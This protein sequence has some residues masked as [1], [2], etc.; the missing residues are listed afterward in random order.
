M[1]DKADGTEWVMPNKTGFLPWVYGKFGALPKDD[2]SSGQSCGKKPTAAV[3]K[4]PTSSIAP[5]Q[6]FIADM[7]HSKT[8]Y[9][10]VLLYHGLGTGKTAA[11]LAAAESHLM[12]NRK[13]FVLLPASLEPNY[14]KEILKVTYI[15]R[16][17]KRPWYKF[18]KPTDATLEAIAKS[19]DITKSWLSKHMKAHDGVLFIPEKFLNEAVEL[20]PHPNKVAYK[21]M[22][23]DDKSN[24]S[25]VLDEIINRK[26]TFIKYNGIS[27]AKANAMTKSTFNNAVVVIDEAHNF[28]LR[29]ANKSPIAERL[30][31]LLMFA[32]NTKII[33]LSGT[34]M[35]NHP[36]ELC[37]TLNLLRG[38]MM[39][40][41]AILT[42]SAKSVPTELDVLNVLE[43][44]KLTQYIDSISVPMKGNA[45]RFTLLPYGYVNTA[46]SQGDL[47]AITFKKWQYSPQEL[48]E[49]IHSTLLSHFEVTPKLRD[50]IG[51]ALPRTREEFVETF[52]NID[53]YDYTKVDVKNAD[54]FMRRIVGLVSYYKTAGE[55]MF[56]T[57][58]PTNIHKLSMPAHQFSAYKAARDKER[59]MEAKKKGP[60][61]G[62]FA[63]KGQVYRAFS[64]MACNF[65][66][67]ETIKRPDMK[68][69]RELMKIEISGDNADENLK[70][71]GEDEEIEDKE[72]NAKGATKG[73]TKAAV[74]K[75]YES[76]LAKALAELYK[77]R[78][79]FLT[80]QELMGKYSP[81]FGK[82]VESVVASP[83]PALFYSQFRTIEGIGIMAIALETAG[84]KE[85]EVYREKTSGNW[86]I[87]DEETVLLP[88][89]NGK[90]FII[91]PDDREKTEVLLSIYNGRIDQTGDHLSEALKGAH[92]DNL[93][94][95]LVKLL[96]ITQS[97]AE[98]ISLRNLRRVEIA[99]PF[100][101]QIRIDQVIGRAVR[102]CSHEDLPAA[103][104]VVTV[105]MYVMQLTAEQL[106]E[107]TLRIADQ[108][109]T[110]D[111]H[112]F[113]LATKKQLIIQKFLDMLQ[114]AA[115]DCV[116]NAHIN[117]PLKTS[118]ACYSFHINAS[119][120]AQ[121]F[122]PI[123]DD[124]LRD[125][126]TNVMQRF[127]TWKGVVVGDGDA[128]E[129]EYGDEYDI[130]AWRNAGVGYKL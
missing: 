65:V 83:G 1:E 21:D 24:S 96:M 105:N 8:P 56:P 45:V 109:L 40:H 29:V 34:P 6:R 43:D 17:K 71:K 26:Y 58:E 128:V 122:S 5:H 119:A 84:F 88:K 72:E 120:D 31:E 3:A 46:T 110:T 123:F 63:D 57:L 2:G 62:L 35:I 98:G 124:D 18:T 7:M 39:V 79:E 41:E 32:K 78:N 61:N 38:P 89:Y 112:I 54:L 51:F 37:H 100:W 86:R 68:S 127:K 42:Q 30:Y 92:K 13:V 106:K 91:F 102:T 10:G 36:F 11:S 23:N 4:Q 103:E 73:T 99:E 130:N 95:E 66:F 74:A 113:D 97:G 75:K 117:K 104:R 9:R 67:P 94:G 111:Q 53:P 69:I 87:R 59:K 76:D 101:N 121:S 108:G 27:Q 33:L 85:I 44:A 129:N 107:P 77:K 93:H 82:I 22:S 50:V 114:K 48:T 60:S 15:G 47:P 116:R 49:K 16:Q 64:R 19:V 115:I 80:V 125:S 52:L 70:N 28:M 14:K 90:R 81:K 25:D 55:N 20:S 12:K 118:G 126:Q